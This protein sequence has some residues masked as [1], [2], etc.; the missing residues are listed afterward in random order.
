MFKPGQPL[1]DGLIWIA[2]Q[3]PGYVY[4][5]DVTNYLRVGF[6]ESFNVPFDE[7]VYN[8]S[9]FRALANSFGNSYTYSMCPRATIFRYENNN[10]FLYFLKMNSSFIDDKPVLWRLLMMPR[11]SFVI[12]IGRMILYLWV[13]QETKSAPAMTSPQ[14]VTGSPLILYPPPHNPKTLQS[15]T[16][17]K[18]GLPSEVLMAR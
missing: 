15:L 1:T 6:W 4:R 10:N 12:I 3:I 14:A 13:M 5:A 17:S 16:L 7:Y 9:G 11:S 2:E 8:V 18:I